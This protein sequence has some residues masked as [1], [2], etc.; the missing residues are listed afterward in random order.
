MVVLYGQF[1]M[2]GQRNIKLYLEYC[3]LWIRSRDPWEKLREG[4]KFIRNMELEKNV[5]NK[6]DDRITNDEVFQRAKEEILLLKILKIRR[7]SWIGHIMR[8]NEF[9]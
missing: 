5:K 4:R 8:H 1:M 2:H 6:M 9:V 3:A 7:Q